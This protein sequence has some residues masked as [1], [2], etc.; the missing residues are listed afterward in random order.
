MN[1]T[2]K[3]DVFYFAINFMHFFLYQG[4][5]VNGARVVDANNEAENGVI[6]GERGGG[7]SSRYLELIFFINL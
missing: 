3:L 4:Y 6:V 7:Q 5:S 1:K 2:S